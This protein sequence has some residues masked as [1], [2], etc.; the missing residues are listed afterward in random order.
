MLDYGVRIGRGVEIQTENVHLLLSGLEYRHG[1]GHPWVRWMLDS[2]DY[3]GGDERLSVRHYLRPVR[4]V[5]ALG[6]SHARLL[7]VP[8]LSNR[9]CVWPTSRP[10][11]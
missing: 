1:E 7:V 6:R 2:L 10:Y 11:I 3:R 5:A 8:C 4:P 9:T